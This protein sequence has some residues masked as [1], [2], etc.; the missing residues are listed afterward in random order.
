MLKYFYGISLSFT[1]IQIFRN[2]DQHSFNEGKSL[3][4]DKHLQLEKIFLKYISIKFFL[5]KDE[6]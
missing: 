2:A 4:I 5:G 6:I 3:G 1:N